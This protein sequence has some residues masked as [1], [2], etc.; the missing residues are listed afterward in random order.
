MISNFFAFFERKLND[1]FSEIMI[2]AIVVM[3]M[4]LTTWAAHYADLAL[5]SKADLLGTASVIAAVAGVPVAMFTLLFNKY[6][7]LRSAGKV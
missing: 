7:E 1:W 4:R 3:C 2:A 5:T 6:A